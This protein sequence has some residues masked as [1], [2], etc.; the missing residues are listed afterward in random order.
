M[1]YCKWLI[2]P[3]TAL[4]RY[5]MYAYTNAVCLLYITGC[6]LINLLYMYG[7][8]LYLTCI[9]GLRHQGTHTL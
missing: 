4:E 1:L 9:V 7:Y 5:Q 3:R 2:C 6:V 8:T